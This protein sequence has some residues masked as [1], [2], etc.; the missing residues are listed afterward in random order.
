MLENNPSKIRIASRLSSSSCSFPNF[1]L[2]PFF[3]KLSL[4]Y[5]HLQ[6][7]GWGTSL[8]AYESYL[9]ARVGFGDPISVTSFAKGQIKTFPSVIF[10]K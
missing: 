1:F 8:D 7:L 3:F 4:A 6:S 2:S 10:F 9:I 5:S